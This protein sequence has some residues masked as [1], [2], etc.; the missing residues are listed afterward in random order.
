MKVYVGVMV[1]S[2]MISLVVVFMVV[3]LLFRFF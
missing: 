3:G 2:F 1:I